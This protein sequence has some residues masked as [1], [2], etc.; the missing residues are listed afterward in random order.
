MREQSVLER[1]GK[2]GSTLEAGYLL[3]LTEKELMGRYRVSTE[4]GPT[5]YERAEGL[6][7]LCPHESMS[8]RF[9]P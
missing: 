3:W 7:R 2:E 8:E 9:A 1:L 6:F 5:G 4:D